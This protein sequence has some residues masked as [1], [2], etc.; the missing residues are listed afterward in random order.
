[1]EKKCSVKKINIIRKY[2]TT[3]RGINWKS[4]DHPPFWNVLIIIKVSFF[5]HI[6]Y[7]IWHLTPQYRRKTRDHILNL[8]L[9]TH[10]NKK[11]NL[12]LAHFLFSINLSDDPQQKSRLVRINKTENCFCAPEINYY[13]R[14]HSS[15]NLLKRSIWRNN[16]GC[17]Y[18][19]TFLGNYVW[20]FEWTGPWEPP[21][22][23]TSREDRDDI[24][25]M[26][27]HSGQ[28]SNETTF[29]LSSLSAG[30]WSLQYY[31]C[32]RRGCRPLMP[33]SNH[34]FYQN[35]NIPQ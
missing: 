4:Q 35:S 7:F 16:L 17:H 14:Q 9:T 28:F 8:F 3:H 18:G 30:Q 27:G 34:T 31:K 23:P 19:L 6:S 26:P 5:T 13:R 33:W 22:L 29:Y 24:I 32:C 21:D 25:G 2:S 10:G 15:Q 12:N 1:M 11:H 20:L